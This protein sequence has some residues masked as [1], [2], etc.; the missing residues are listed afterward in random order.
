M[1]IFDQAKLSS[2]YFSRKSLKDDELGELLKMYLFTP[3]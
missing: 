1:Y 3:D 2:Y